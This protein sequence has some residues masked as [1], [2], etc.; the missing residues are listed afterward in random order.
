MSLSLSY[1]TMPAKSVFSAQYEKS[2]AEEGK[3]PYSSFRVGNDPFFGEHSF[4][5]DELFDQCKKFARSPKEAKQDWV[6][7]VL[8]TIGI[9]WI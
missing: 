6:S 4:T 5:C 8:T 1:G 7:C 3:S 2:F 9:E